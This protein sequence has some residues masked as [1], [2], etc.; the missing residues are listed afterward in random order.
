VLSYH[1]LC[2]YNIHDVRDKLSQSFHKKKSDYG[3]MWGHAPAVQEIKRKNRKSPSEK[4]C[5]QAWT[6]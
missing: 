6:S 1:H 5:D 4:D 3:P 2:A